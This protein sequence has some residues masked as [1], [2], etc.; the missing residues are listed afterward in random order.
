MLH[1][2][3]VALG[4]L[5]LPGCRWLLPSRPQYARLPHATSPRI[6]V[7]C[8]VINGRD[9]PVF[10][11]GRQAFLDSDEDRIKKLLEPLLN[12]LVILISTA[13]TVDEE[14]TNPDV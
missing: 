9:V 13:P 8:H 4:S 6:D 12:L 7:H 10:E 11:F 2:C 3:G 14:L 5:G 1:G